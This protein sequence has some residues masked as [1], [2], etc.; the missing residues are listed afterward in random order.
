MLKNSVDQRYNGCGLCYVLTMHYCR[1]RV[2]KLF[3]GV[4]PAG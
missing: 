1:E 3:Q 2:F 4:E